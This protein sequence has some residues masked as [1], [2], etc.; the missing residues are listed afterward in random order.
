MPD[1]LI[2]AVIGVVVQ[3]PLF[4]LVAW[5]IRQAPVRR[6]VTDESELS[7]LGSRARVDETLEI[8][9]AA[10]TDRQES[11]VAWHEAGKPS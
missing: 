9:R 10:R 1:E 7:A 8:E 3:V 4:V 2:V 11:T 5:K 6:V